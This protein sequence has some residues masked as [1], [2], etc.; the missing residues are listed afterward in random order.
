MLADRAYDADSLHDTILD[1]GGEPVIPPRRHRKDQH[2]YD[3][4][5]YRQRRGIEGFFAK[6]KQCAASL[7]A[8]TSSPQPPRLRQARQ[9]HALA[10]VIKLNCHHLHI[11]D[12]IAASPSIITA[13]DPLGET[14][15]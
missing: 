3:R 10:Q 5:V 12:D 2:G 7:P 13:F 11:V 15:N 1:Q 14:K 6:L 9:H 8:T 4:I